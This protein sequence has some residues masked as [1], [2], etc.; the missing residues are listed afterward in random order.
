MSRRKR[1]EARMFLRDTF[2]TFYDKDDLSHNTLLQY[3]RALMLWEQFTGNP[4]VGEVTDET[5]ALFR[6]K[7]MEQYSPA[8]VKRYWIALRAMFRRIGPQFTGNPTGLGFIERIPYMKSIRI[9]VTVPKTVDL[10]D[11][12]KFYIACKG[13]QF[14]FRSGVRPA[15]WWQTL[16]VLGYCTG[17]RTTDLLTIRREDIDLDKGTLFVSAAKTV[18]QDRFPLH[19]VAVEHVRR[20]WEPER[21]YLFAQYGKPSRDNGDV[22]NAW[23]GI[24]EKA[25][26]PHFTLRDVRR[27][28]ASQAE[29]IRPGAGELLLQHARYDVT[30]RHYLD[31]SSVLDDVIEKLPIPLAFKHGINLELK[32]QEKA[33]R[34]QQKRKLEPRNFATPG[35]PE[36]S[37][38]MFQR[39]PRPSAFWFRGQW[40]S[41]AARYGTMLKALAKSEKPVGF[42]CFARMFFGQHVSRQSESVRGRVHAEISDLRQILRSY[43]GLPKN[44]NPIP[45]VSRGS[46]GEW[47]LY[48][49]PNVA[50][51]RKPARIDTPEGMMV[52]RIRAGLTQSRLGEMLGV[53]HATVSKWEKGDARPPAK[54]IAMLLQILAPYLDDSKGG[55]A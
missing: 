38:W 22:R 8:T 47:T 30:W 1:S 46:G 42:M 36:P 34:D 7:A 15:Y 54:R 21:E 27:T 3:R 17:L 55:A 53:S 26:V 2:E 6:R 41:I 14:P 35:K 18:K 49:P 51:E 52:A 16:L 43:F 4:E 32:A 44:W 37:E 9:P 25:G 5:M 24:R 19:P 28:A 45:C 20:I 23:H 31:L 29:M 48:L 10:E 39:H 13:A 33:E 50:I 11:L 40:Y 12:S